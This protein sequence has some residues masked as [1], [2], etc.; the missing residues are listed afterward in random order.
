MNDGP[1]VPPGY[2]IVDNLT[3]YLMTSGPLAG[4]APGVPPYPVPLRGIQI[5]IRCFEPDS[6]QIREITIEHDFLPK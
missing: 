5:K 3:E 6:K 2:T 4:Y 1:P